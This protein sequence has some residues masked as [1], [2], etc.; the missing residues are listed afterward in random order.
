M[1]NEK[2]VRDKMLWQLELGKKELLRSQEPKSIYDSPICPAAIALWDSG[3][4]K[5]FRAGFKG[6]GDKREWGRAVSEACRLTHATG[7]ILRLAA[8][9]LSSARY[10]EE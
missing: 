9:M 5:E 1:L 2:V 10:F 8:T 4:Q 3:R 6:T 7:L